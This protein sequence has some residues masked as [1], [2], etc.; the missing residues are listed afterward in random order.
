MALSRADVVDRNFM[1]YVRALSDGPSRSDLDSPAQD[2][3]RLT[4]RMAIELFMAQIESRL[5][6]LLSREL[7]KEG[8][9]FYTIGSSGHEGNA[10]VAAALQPNDPAFLHYR[11]GGFYMA[12]A[13]QAPGPEGPLDVILGLMARASEPIAGGRHKVFGSLPLA[14]PPQTSTIASHLPK[15]LG[16]AVAIDR[17]AR[18][19]G[20]D[21]RRIVVC[22]FGDASANHSTAA[23]ALNS[24]AWTTFQNVPAPVLFVCEDN[25]FGI[26]VRTPEGWIENAY[27]TRPGRRPRPRPRVRDGPVRCRGGSPQTATGI[28][29]SQD[30]ATT[31]ARGI[32]RRAAVPHHE[33]GRVRRGTRPTASDRET[34]GRRRMA[35]G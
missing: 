24:A 22:S 29:A 13:R 28:P 12:R 27:S 33:R 31:R 17:A 26:S 3:S 5:C 8:L 4:G 10:A 32:R 1:R 23:G 34:I 30:R 25:G 14:I 21:D 20:V 11:S 9:S 35:H 2:Q 7:K 15:A 6:D 18:F 19:R 16:C